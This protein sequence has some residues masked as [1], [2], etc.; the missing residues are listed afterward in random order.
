LQRAAF[1]LP[2]KRCPHRCIYCDQGAITGEIGLP[3]PDV[4]RE[5][6]KKFTQK[7]ELCFFGGSFTCLDIREQRSYLDTVYSAP[8]GSV[9]RFSTH[10]LCISESILDLMKEY[11]IS[12][13]ELGISSLSNDVL[14][15]CKRGY[16][17]QEAVKAMEMIVSYGF[18]LGAQM[19]IGL[20][21]QDEASSLDDIDKIADI[22][23]DVPI[24]L[25][26]YPCLVIRN[27]A[28]ERLYLSGMY[29]PLGTEEAAIWSGNILYK[30]LSLGM[31]VQRIG[32]Q[33]TDSLNDSVTAGPHHPA[34]GEMARSRAL[35][36][37][38]TSKRM[39]G[40]WEIPKN[41]ISLIK[42]HHCFGLRILASIVCL[43]EEETLRK[44]SFV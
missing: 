3:E 2:N 39:K 42:G 26:I 27:T 21:G 4:I 35:A 7:V 9:V 14:K 10:P 41:K 15:T 34:L 16:N 28:L 38:L 23:R 44:I 6:L 24:T 13:I 25:R 20:P 12:M 19:M 33:E 40:P 37:E 31:K 1:F 30:A 29:K 43:S 17:D 18:R 8:E 36:L 22:T 32:L 11:P 5:F